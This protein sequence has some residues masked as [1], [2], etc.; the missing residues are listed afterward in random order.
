MTA[1]PAKVEQVATFEA[2]CLYVAHRDRDP[3]SM[4][5]HHPFKPSFPGPAPTWAHLLREM[6]LLVKPTPMPEPRREK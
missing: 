3:M 6:I 4:F 5:I 1:I 2:Y